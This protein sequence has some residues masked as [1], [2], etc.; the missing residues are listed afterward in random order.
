MNNDENKDN[1]DVESNGFG[2]P[3]A[4]APRPKEPENLP[5]WAKITS[6]IVEETED[7][8][9]LFDEKPKRE[10]YV[11]PKKG[12]GV[13]MED[14]SEDELFLEETNSVPTRIV[15][16]APPTPRLRQETYN[17]EVSEPVSARVEP[18]PNT[19]PAPPAATSRAVPE[20]EEEYEE[21]VEPEEEYEEE[22]N[23]KSLFKKVPKAKQKQPRSV[24]SAKSVK[25]AIAT[26]VM[27]K[28]SDIM[29]PKGRMAGNRWKMIGLRTAV[30][31][32]LG[33]IMFSGVVTIFGPKGPSITALT[34]QVLLNL[35]RNNFPLES[36]Q[37]LASR[38]AKE[39]LN[40]NPATSKERSD[41]LKTYIAGSSSNESLVTNFVADRPLRVIGEPILAQPAEL[42]SDS[43]VI[44]TFAVQVFQ[45]A[46]AETEDAPGLPATPPEWIYLAVPVSA[47]EDGSVGV[48]GMPAFVPQPKIAETAPNMIL[49]DD[50][51]A[52]LSALPQIERFLAH[53]AE[54]DEVALK[55]YLIEGLST[56]G[57]SVGLG[58]TVTFTAVDKL[59][60]EAFPADYV[61]DPEVTPTCAPPNY[62]FPCRKAY[63]QASWKYGTFEISNNYRMVLLFDG[64]NWRVIDIRGAH[65]G[66]IGG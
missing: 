32:T 3:E 53:W 48:A 40:L 5:D 16:E 51:E 45:P 15:E 47:A 37:H 11:P 52:R 39:Y 44:F 43:H 14:L 4:P 42:I 30:W 36:G 10:D 2:V 9:Q 64:Q 65:F 6:S 62:D 26:G 58:G 19:P 50:R 63:V 23:K 17:E 59:T 46:V 61:Q 24:K 18:K 31:G 7:A 13:P 57:A 66:P 21:E 41:N 22:I 20:Y 28:E 35:N 27:G 25:K 54:S 55:P 49:V 1:F 56:S 34:Q 29:A 8:G 33:L 12:F 38:F 60:V